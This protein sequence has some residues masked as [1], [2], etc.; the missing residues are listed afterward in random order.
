[1]ITLDAQVRRA[2]AQDRQRISSL[3]FYESNA[4]RHLDWRSALD[5]LGSRHYWTLE[6]D[7]RI[8]A[9][10]ACPQDPPR[11]GWIRLFA[12]QP[13]LSA[14]EAWSALWSAASAEIVFDNP[15]MQVAAIIVK[16]WFQKILLSSGFEVMQN[17]ILLHLDIHH[18]HRFPAAREVCIRPMR[19]DDLPAVAQI[20]R[21][22]F[23]PFWHNT[24]D[25]LRRAYSQSVCASVAESD[26][27]V[28]GYQISTGQMHRAHL[29][30]LGVRPEAQGRG[31][32]TALMENLVHR[33]Q[34]DRIE[35]LSVNTQADNAASLALYRKMGFSR[36]GEYFPVL[37]H[38]TE[39]L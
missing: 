31:V 21:A 39:R 35:G 24:L 26:A 27:G 38:P 13:P 20:D 25:S 33:L 3:L 10:L 32:G 19:E 34:A 18:A 22:A 14:A 16:Q 9:A 17:I 23:G 29:A 8:V 4:H 36:T 2:V 1:M 12:Y 7:G 11:V 15:P 37:V 5:W 6:Q 30:R 28:E